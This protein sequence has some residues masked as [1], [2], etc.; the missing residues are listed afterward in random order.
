MLYLNFSARIRRRKTHY[1]QEKQ[2]DQQ[3]AD[4]YR[5]QADKSLLDFIESTRQKKLKQKE[6]KDMYDRAMD[7]RHKVKQIE[8]Q[9]DEVS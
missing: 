3:E 9:L 6:V 4:E 7:E 8:Q 5:R 2:S 1:L